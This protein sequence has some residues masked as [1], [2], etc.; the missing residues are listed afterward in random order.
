MDITQKTDPARPLCLEIEDAKM[1]IFDAINRASKERHIPFYLLESI[2][3]DAAR[4]VAKL[5]NAERETAKRA[6][7]DQLKNCISDNKEET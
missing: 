1:E 2:V 4:Q 7:E 3:D 6:Y 5:A